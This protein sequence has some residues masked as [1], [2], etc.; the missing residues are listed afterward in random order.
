MRSKLFCLTAVLFSVLASLGGAASAQAPDAPTIIRHYR[1]LPRRSVLNES[2]GKPPRDVDFRVFGPFDFV[3]GWDDRE[4]PWMGRSAKFENVEAWASHPIL[5]Y[6]LFLNDVLNMEGLK[7]KQLPVAA[8]FDVYQFEGST[9]DG[10]SVQLFV[11][12]LGPWLHLRG[13]TTPP[14][15]SADMLVY[16]LR[17]TARQIPFADFDGDEAVGGE[18]LGK[19]S[20][21]YGSTPTVDGAPFGDANDDHVVDGSDFLTWQRQLGQTAPADAVVDAAISAALAA[22]AASLSAVPEPNSLGLAAVGAIVV[23][24]ARRR[25]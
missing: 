11:S 15:G 18:D 10:S 13:E 17:A 8:P 24:R 19:W 6:V 3:T 21:G 4:D 22:Q 5:A 12:D 23:L 2:G 14:P 9:Q 25:G 20:A 7:G 16:K 1:F